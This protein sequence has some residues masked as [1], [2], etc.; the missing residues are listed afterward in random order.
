MSKK[1]SETLNNF[2]RTHNVTKVEFC[3]LSGVSRTSL[4]SYLDGGPI[5]RRQAKMIR[6]YLSENH[7]IEVPIKDLID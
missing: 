3:L 5:H 7:G 6:D 2:F 4:Y 1:A